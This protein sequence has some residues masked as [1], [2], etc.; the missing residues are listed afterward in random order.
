[1]TEISNENFREMFPIVKEA[2]NKSTFI[3]F[4]IN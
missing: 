2:I 3:G 1:M 4:K